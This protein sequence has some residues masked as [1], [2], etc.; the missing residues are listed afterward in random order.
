MYL[1][2]RQLLNTVLDFADAPFKDFPMSLFSLLDDRLRRLRAGM[3][4]AGIDA[5]IIPRFDEHQGEYCAPH[6]ERLAYVTGFTGSA[7]ICLVL[8][9]RAIIFVDG[10][11]QVQV[12]NQVNPGDYEIEHF[13]DAPIEQWLERH[14]T[15]SLGVGFNPMLIPASL[16]G[17]LSRALE[18]SGGRLVALPSDP[19]DAIWNDQPEKPLAPIT[20]FALEHAGET[21]ASKR[22]L[23]AARLGE[24]GADLL[25]ETQP[26]N[27]AWLLNVRGADVAFNPIPHSFLLL[28]TDG[29]AEWFVDPRKLP[30]DRTAFELEDVTLGAP[31]DF[32]GRVRAR[33][34]GRT[35]LVDPEFAPV[36]AALAVRESQGTV[37]AQLGPIT[38]AKAAKNATEL[39]GFRACHIED[40]AAW[41][42]FLAWLHAHGPD[43]QAA[44]KPITE[45]EAEAQILSFR[46]PRAGFVEPSFRSISASGSNAA[47]C[48]YAASQASDSPIVKGGVYLLDSGGQY[49]GGT[50]DATRTTAF[51]TVGAE[52]RRAYTAVLKGFIAM[53]TLRFPLGTFGHQIDAFSRRPLWDLGLDFDHGAGHGVGHFLSVHEQP[54]RFE[55][56][57][58]NYRL[59]AGLV[60][61]VEP[62]YYREGAFGLRIENQVEVVD[63]GN[64]FLRFASLTHIPIDLSLADIGAL[65]PD[66]ITF[67]DGYHRQVRDALADR[68]VPE[69]RDFLIAATVPIGGG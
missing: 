2:C 17:K 24:L 9:D 3:S 42:G 33:S 34:A 65:A 60:M 30:N 63:A 14:A 46:R 25:V 29:K 48:H 59:E 26:D 68:I 38:L 41:V 7:G 44:G 19:V 62:G 37:L 66:E 1:V 11:Y 10:R 23:I 22:R 58:N 56:I 27:I 39:E 49:L 61:T 28:D 16:H 6:D 8:R 13:D 53:M 15:A 32:I 12:R 21:S 57:A 45:L 20:A 51:G 69:A 55:N 54:H 52:V 18:R 67:L 31:E 5:L 35:V 50:T 64:G 4:E 43:R 40:G 36:A 47:M